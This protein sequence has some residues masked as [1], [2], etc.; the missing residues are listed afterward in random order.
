VARITVK[1]VYEVPHRIDEGGEVWR[2]CLSHMHFANSRVGWA[3][4][5]AQVLYTQNGG[6]TWVN[7]YGNHSDYTYLDPNRVFAV[8][9]RM[10]WITAIG[11][12]TDIRCC[13][14][15]DGGLT[16]KTKELETGI[17]PKDIFFLDPKRGWIVSNDGHLPARSSTILFTEDR[18][19]S[20]ESFNVG[21]RGN[22]NRIR[23]VN[24]KKGWLLQDSFDPKKTKITSKLSVSY[25]GGHS[26]QISKLFDRE[27]RDFY[28]LGDE[29]LFAI[30]ENGFIAKTSDDGKKWKRLRTR[31][32]DCIEAIAFYKHET[33]IAVGASGTVLLSRDEGETWE[34]TE[35]QNNENYDGAS[36]VH[37]ISGLVG[38]LLSG[39][40]IFSFKLS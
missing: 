4:G 30:G 37:F 9:P 13:Y 28:I 35:K 20:W 36:R 11:G 16:W 2:R 29:H 17:H 31:T 3:V 6:R 34:E 25:D 21:I 15:Q 14:T 38:V 5:S 1:N 27:I 10:G 7:Q 33:G 18:G 24:D 23:F 40:S 26:W 32:R 8:S 12:H 19:V 39:T 22:P